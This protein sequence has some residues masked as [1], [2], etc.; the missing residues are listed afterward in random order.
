[1]RTLLFSVCSVDVV[2][3]LASAPSAQVPTIFT[4]LPTPPA[5]TT[6]HP[7]NHHH[8][9]RNHHHKT[10]GADGMHRTG[11]KRKGSKK[12]GDRKAGSDTGNGPPTITHA[13]SHDSLSNDPLNSSNNSSSM[14]HDVSGIGS[15]TESQEDLL[16]SCNDKN[17]RNRQGQKTMGEKTNSGSKVADLISSYEETAR[18]SQSSSESVKITRVSEEQ[19]VGREEE[20]EVGR[21]KVGRVMSMVTEHAFSQ[22]QTLILQE[23]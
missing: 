12:E 9:H 13:L 18:L 23:V 10:S 15:N 22:P 16:D 4:S 2:P 11:H 5:I 1:M 3:V 7:H 17:R 19:G 14:G 8:H 6:S 21:G 20:E